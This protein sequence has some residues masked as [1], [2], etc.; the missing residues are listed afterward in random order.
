[1]I[2]KLDLM[3]FDVSERGLELIIEKELE[4]LKN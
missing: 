2:Q 3:C 4:T 1:M